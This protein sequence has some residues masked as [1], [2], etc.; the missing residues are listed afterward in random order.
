M[1]SNNNRVVLASAGSRKTTFVVEEALRT[2][3][4]RVLITTYTNENVAQ[5]CTYLTQRHGH[6]P[7]HVNVMSWYSFLLHRG[8]RP[9]QNQITTAPRVNSILF[10]QLPP[11]ARFIKK[12]NVNQY[13]LSPGRNIYRDRVADFV[14]ECNARTGGLIVNRLGRIYCH[15]LID[16][17]QDLS[18][19][20]LEFLEQLFK[21]ALAVTA[22]GDPRQAT[23][24]TNNAAKNKQYRELNCRLGRQQRKVWPLS[25]RGAHRM[26]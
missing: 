18:G 8:I 7:A 4:G 21:S 22:V 11:E 20:D 9:Y 26:L 5:M 12:S 2:R 3:K 23:Y 6:I 19:Y 1:Q 13:Y 24:S 14:H 17:L 25:H 16:Q 10:G 15:L